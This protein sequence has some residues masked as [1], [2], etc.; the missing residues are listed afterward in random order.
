MINVDGMISDLITREGGY[1]NDPTD[2]GGET[3][4]GITVLEARA[5]GY[6]GPMNALPRATAAMIY[7]NMY[8]VVPR[9]ADVAMTMPKLAAELFD[10]GVNMGVQT[11]SKFLQRALNL[12]N[13]GGKD[14]ADI[15][16]DGQLGN[17]SLYVLGQFHAKRGDMAERVLL[18]AMEGQQLCRYMDIAEKNP[19]QEKF[20]F[21]WIANRVGDQS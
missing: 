12:L 9:F 10:T 7:K 16:V 4:Y 6:P 20:E 1:V 14:Y 2:K 13:N 3:N 18:R 19:T 17:L 5:H 8:W 11:A 21:G 15:K